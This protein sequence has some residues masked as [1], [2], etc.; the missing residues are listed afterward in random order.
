[1]F[2][3]LQQL[4]RSAMTG[5]APAKVTSLIVEDDTEERLQLVDKIGSSPVFDPL[6][7]DN[8]RKGPLMQRAEKAD[9]VSLDLEVETRKAESRYVCHQLKKKNPYKS[10]LF[11]T[12]NPKEVLGEPINF[13]LEKSQQVWKSYD[14][15]LMKILIHDRGLGLLHD[16]IQLS[17]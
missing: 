9:I 3:S 7:Y 15:L 16:V 8:Y 11:F 13:V 1:M 10:V 12:S 6:F 17:G 4:R 2:A 5:F 14:R